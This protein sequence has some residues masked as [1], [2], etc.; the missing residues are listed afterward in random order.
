M[1]EAKGCQLI[2]ALDVE[3]REEALATLKTLGGS[4]QW[5]KIGLQLFTA[6]GPDIV[7]E[8][9]ELGYRVF[10]DLKLHDI[11]NT[12]SKAV[13]SIAQLPVELLT[14]HAFG[15]AE[16]IEW[17]NQ[18]RL[19]HAPKLNLL[20]VTVLTSMS[21]AQL[22][23][24]NIPTTAEAQVRHLAE[25]SLKAGAQGLVCSSLELALLRTRFGTDPLLV[26][27]GIRPKGS[28][29]DEQKRVMTPALAA[30]AGSNFIVVGRPIL[31]AEDPAAAAQ[32]ITAELA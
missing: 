25:V 19:D 32:A 2:L 27:P 21:G 8:I 7:R 5:V 26:T 10:L 30:K 20:A 15:G 9:H 6:C 28:E 24:L 16:M 1:N 22:R 3:T 31:R 17:A 4:L 14:L 13:Q 12:V 18:A 29:S 11:P 23:S